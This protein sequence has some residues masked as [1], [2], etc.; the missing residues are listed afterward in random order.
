[1]KD[2]YIIFSLIILLS[3]C[4]SRITFVHDYN[5]KTIIDEK[6]NKNEYNHFNKKSFDGLCEIEYGF[7]KN[8]E[9][10]KAYNADGK[11]VARCG[12][13]FTFFID[14]ERIKRDI[15]YGNL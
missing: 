2:K 12:P 8:P 13:P 11:L 9:L 7:I 15:E 14:L 10:I 5:Y 3:S 4:V 1:M 6:P